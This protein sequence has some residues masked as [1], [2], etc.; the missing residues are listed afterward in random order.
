MGSGLSL[1]TKAKIKKIDPA[2]LGDP[3]NIV[4]KLADNIVRLGLHRR[5][6]LYLFKECRPQKPFEV[7]NKTEPIRHSHWS[8]SVL[9]KNVQTREYIVDLTAFRLFGDKPVHRLSTASAKQY[10]NDI[11]RL[12]RG[13]CE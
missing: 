4:R 13:V 1:R 2:E 10:K 12:L 6:A 8:Q 3:F 9:S 5:E 7:A 11:S